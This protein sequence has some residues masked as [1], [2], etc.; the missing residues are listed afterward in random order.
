MKVSQEMR[1]SLSE[2][3]N[4]PD[5]RLLDR[6]PPEFSETDAQSIAFELYGLK[7]AFTQ[8]ESERDVN[9]L[10]STKS[11]EEYVL[12]LSNSADDPGDIDFQI[13]AHLHLEK[14]DP[15]FPAPRVVRTK[16]GEAFTLIM[17]PESAEHA[18]HMLTYVPGTPM[19]EMPDTPA[20]WR[21]LGETLA[22]MDT[23]TRGFFHPNA[24]RYIPWD[25]TRCTDLR[26]HTEH[27]SNK[28]ARQNIET[29]L[30]HMAEAILPR[31]KATR[32]QI[33]HGDANPVNAVVDPQHPEK[34]IGLIDFGD[35]VFAPLITDLAIATVENILLD[36]ELECLR[37]LV[38]GFDSV[39]PLEEPEID[40]LYDL[41]LARRALSATIIAWR[42]AMTPD[43][44]AY[45]VD[46]E[47]PTW[48]AITNLMTMGRAEVTER[49]RSVCR[50]PAY[51]P[52]G[53]T[54]GE[55]DIA[56]D[57]FEKRKSILGPNLSHFYGKPLHFERGRGPWLFD[58]RGKPYLDAYNNVPVTGHCHPHVVRA[59]ER[60]AAALNTNTR[61]LY[62]NIVEYAERLA[63]LF[64]GGL[65]ACAF[66]NSG[67]EANDIAWRMARFATGARGALVMEHA[68]HG[69]TEAT[70]DM[71]ASEWIGDRPP[72]V[73]TLSIPDPYRAPDG[74]EGAALTA[75]HAVDADRAIADLA[76]RGIRPA[77]FIVDT[78]FSSCGIPDVPPGYLA[79]VV[80]KVRVAGGLFISDEVQAGFGRCGSDMW[81]FS[82]HDVA[83]DIVTL[84]KP[85]GSGFPLGVVV[86]R[87]EI[88]EPLAS[89]TDLFSTFGGNPVACAA[90]LAVLDVIED[91][92]L[93]SNAEDVGS[94]LRSGIQSLMAR[95]A[96][97]GDV[98]GRGLMVAVELVLD[99]TSKEPA[100]TEATRLLDLMRDE[101][102]LI[103]R[104]GPLKNVLKIRPP[105]VFQ[106]NHADILIG[107]LDRSLGKL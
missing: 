5:I 45:L 95:H 84:G 53:P 46:R 107:A 61:Y 1:C 33:I 48:D 65:S 69:I 25:I 98:R 12:K 79:A 93:L 28:R 10:I 62:R 57:L 99:R 80:S 70:Y 106:R 11:D 32:H 43:Q 74:L 22:R 34:V 47:Q 72:H 4:T 49:L 71:S 86:T 77:V 104:S 21:S 82:A 102:V 66:F 76:E 56:H 2:Q 27:V 64:D 39:L 9:F 7:G 15:D 35:M 67:S 60:Q 89:Q 31:L 91:E 13:C 90:G 30:D 37:A 100:S 29:I 18:V 6:K 54:D 44:P 41:I 8:L 23:A 52:L 88:L 87:P 75:H 19:A 20:R 78:I 55:T 63:D 42:R 24:R 101:G 14:Q 94:Y 50:F 92:D 97:I 3:E 58:A 105:L 38:S 96:L 103:G 16:M 81:G 83:P 73:E 26:P 85:V 51:M 40:L 59:I 17:G 36:Q 68:Y